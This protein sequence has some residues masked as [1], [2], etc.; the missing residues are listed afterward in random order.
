MSERSAGGLRKTSIRITTKLYINS[1][2][3]VW[4]L[5]R[6]AQARACARFVPLVTTPELVLLPAASALRGATLPTQPPRA[7][8]VT[9]GFTRL[10]GREFAPRARQES[11]H[12]RRLQF[13]LTAMPGKGRARHLELAKTAQRGSTLRRPLMSALTATPGSLVEQVIERSE[14]AF[15]KTRRS[16]KCA[17]WLQT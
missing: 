2:Q 7:Q 17:K 3:F 10:L 1:T 15:W 9:K 5:L 14:R 12:R 16:M 4:R 6:S 11:S 13:A 8:I